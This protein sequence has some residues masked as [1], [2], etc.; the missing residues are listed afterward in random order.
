MYQLAEDIQKT[1]FLQDALSVDDRGFFSG[2]YGDYRLRTAYQPIMQVDSSFRSQVFGQEALVR[3]DRNGVF[4]PP[5]EFLSNV[6][7]DDKYHVERMCEE[8]HIKNWQSQGDTSAL[9]FMN[10]NVALLDD[11]N[12][13][14]KR[15][16]LAV[17]KTDMWGVDP[18]QLVCELVESKVGS[19]KKLKFLVDCLSEFGVRVA[20]DDFGVDQ[21]NIERVKLLRPDFVKLDGTFFH[22]FAA[23]GRLLPMLKGLT[24]RLRDQG[25]EIIVEAVETEHHRDTAL[26][27]DVALMQGYYYA[28]PKMLGS[29]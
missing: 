29:D 2:A 17:S 5:A 13:D 11:E 18:D 12:V 19:V 4:T 24:N 23:N 26:D 21:S 7:K 9:L 15:I 8:I 22:R 16:A 14:A 27:C 25:G 1:E 20:V 10:I 28:K 6:P 3:C